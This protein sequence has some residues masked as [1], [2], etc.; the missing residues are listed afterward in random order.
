MKNYSYLFIILSA[1]L[2]TGCNAAPPVSDVSDVWCGADISLEKGG[3]EI[4]ADRGEPEIASE[5]N[6]LRLG[7]G[8]SRERARARARATDEPGLI[9]FDRG[10]W[11][12]E[13]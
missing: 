3:L 8:A 6:V 1:A 2:I 5:R 13:E 10:S 11:L 9:R 7:S 12:A 4:E